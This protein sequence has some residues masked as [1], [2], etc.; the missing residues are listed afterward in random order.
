MRESWRRYD[1]VIAGTMS[2]VYKIV[3][4]TLWRD[5]ERQGTFGGAPADLA[6]GFIHLSTAGQVAETA[7]RHFASQSGLLLVAISADQL[8]D[9]LRWE[10]SRGGA[11]FPHLYAQLPLSAVLWAKP[12]PLGPDGLHQFPILED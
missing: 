9:A 4:E 7:A 5:A 10:P 1:G 3:S 11:L 8:G 2:V 6:D 12:L